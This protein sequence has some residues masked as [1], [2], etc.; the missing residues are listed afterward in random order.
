MSGYVHK[1]RWSGQVNVRNLDN[2]FIG[3]LII[4]ATNEMIIWSA[5]AVVDV[6]SATASAQLQLVE[7]TDTDTVWAN[8][9]VRTAVGVI[10]FIQ[11]IGVTGSDTST[12]YPFTIASKAT[13]RVMALQLDL[14]VG[15]TGAYGFNIDYS[16]PGSK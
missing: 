2:E 10:Q 3:Y 5:Y 4:P 13:D 7:Q 12:T 1:Q 8:A 14:D 16:F 9:D 15:A 6:V 11:V